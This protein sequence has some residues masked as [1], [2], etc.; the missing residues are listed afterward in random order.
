MRQLRKLSRSEIALNQSLHFSV[1]DENGSLLLRKGIV[2]TVPAHIERLL[3]GGIY[4]DME[5]DVQRSNAPSSL[6]RVEERPPVFLVGEQLCNRVKSLYASILRLPDLA[7]AEA[8]GMAIA[9][10]IQEA[11][12]EDPDSLVAALHIDL[13]SAYLLVHQSLGG[14]LTELI[15]AQA[16]M[17]PEDRRVLV[18]AAITRDIAQTA[19]Q[20]ELDRHQGPLTPE[21]RSKIDNHPLLGCELL[22]ASGVKHP[23]WLEAVAGHHE[24][25]D[26]SGYPAKLSGEA[27]SPGARLLAVA[28][29]YSA[30]IK[31][32]PYRAQG[33]AVLSQSALRDIYTDSGNT[34]DKAFSSLL[35]K[36]I[37]ILPAGSIVKLECGEIAVVKNACRNMEDTLVYSIY[38]RNQMP[39]ITSVQRRTSEPGFAIK[40][41]AH[42]SECRSAQATIRRL[43]VKET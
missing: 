19:I 41:L 31:P 9:T 23:L 16:G 36:A 13:T 18:A 17:A 12:A 43:W 7:D 22:K 29:V 38:D 10:L 14:V 37:G 20:A 34:L 1:Y 3:E 35:I 15:A 2:V 33:K 39:Q 11:C 30:M 8:K 26:G 40:G 4:Q 21:L 42:Y 24:R 32:R 5:E 25:M 27:I 28:D 6:P